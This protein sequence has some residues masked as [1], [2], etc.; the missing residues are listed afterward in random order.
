MSGP[1]GKLWS[2]RWWLAICLAAFFTGLY[3]N[4]DVEE[5]PEPS[6]DYGRFFTLDGFDVFTVPESTN[7]EIPIVMHLILSETNDQSDQTTTFVNLV[8]KET[9]IKLSSAL[10]GAY[11]S[12]E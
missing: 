12:V 1:W 6:N 8:D 5:F 7:E 4:E 2:K 3:L 9:T 10:E 11:R